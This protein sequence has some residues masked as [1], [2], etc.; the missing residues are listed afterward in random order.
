MQWKEYFHSV[1][2]G[3]ELSPREWDIPSFTSR[4]IFLLL[5]FITCILSFAALYYGRR[6]TSRIATWSSGILHRKN[7]ALR[8]RRW[9]GRCIGLHVLLDRFVWR[10]WLVVLDSRTCIQSRQIMVFYSRI[11]MCR[12]IKFNR[13]TRFKINVCKFD[14]FNH[15]PR[16]WPQM[17]HIL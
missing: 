15:R 7:G 16:V 2:D 8:R 17:F 3:T 10:K 1:K 4:K 5:T 6:A 9:R 14:Q 13:S 12:S 11:V